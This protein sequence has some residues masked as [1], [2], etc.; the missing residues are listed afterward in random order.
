M[1]EQDPEKLGLE[2]VF[3]G[4]HLQV[5]RT[6]SLFCHSSWASA[7]E[8]SALA[9]FSAACSAVPYWRNKRTGDFSPCGQILQGLKPGPG[10]KSFRQD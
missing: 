8:E 5:R 7:H 2:S 9:T 10:R 6:R 3:E 4:A 1:A